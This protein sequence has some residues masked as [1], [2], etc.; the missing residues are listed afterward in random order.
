MQTGFW[1]PNLG[2]FL[3]V[4]LMRNSFFIFRSVKSS[5]CYYYCRITQ[6]VGWSLLILKNDGKTLL[7]ND[8]PPI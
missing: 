3:F 2:I 6:N 8:W 1:K 4:I 5:T 7:F